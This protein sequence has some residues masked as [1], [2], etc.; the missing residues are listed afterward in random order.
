M[1]SKFTE[2]SKEIKE[3]DRTK[4]HSTLLLE[5]QVVLRNFIMILLLKYIIA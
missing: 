5:F 3:K 4:S 2:K 1:I